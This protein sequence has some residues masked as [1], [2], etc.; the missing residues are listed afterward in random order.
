LH[1]EGSPVQW[2]DCQPFIS[3]YF[4]KSLSS[5]PKY[6]NIL[7]KGLKALIYSGDAD[8]V[9]NFIGTERWITQDGLNLT[10][11]GPWR[12]WLGPDKQIAG[13]VQDF[14]GLTFKTIKGAGHMVPAVRPLHGLNL[15]ECYVYGAD[16][17]ATFKYPSDPYE[18][19]AGDFDSEDDNDDDDANKVE[20]VHDVVQLK[21]IAAASTTLTSASSASSSGL[22]YVGGGAVLLVCGFFVYTGRRRH[23]TARFSCGEERIPF[24]STV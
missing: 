12:S 14:D 7:G 8:S 23:R 2:V 16:T 9:V 11:V 19:E 15:F 5:L 3:K 10:E 24:A 22:A 17:C 20:D 13:Y 1:V 4:T 21:K 18:T 6:R